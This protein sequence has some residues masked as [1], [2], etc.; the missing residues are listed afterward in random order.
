MIKN[1]V[2][3]FLGTL[4]FSILFNVPKKYY[5]YCGLTGMAGWLVYCAAEPFASATVAA[6]F[7]TLVVVLLSRIFAV[8]RKC[9]ITVFLISGI[10]PLVPGASVYYTAYY[11]VTGELRMAAIKGLDSVKIAFAIV[12]GI[13]CVFSIPKQWFQ[14]SHW[15]GRK[16][17]RKPENITKIRNI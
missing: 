5:M 3:S 4:A 11:L 17:E 6:F 14:V 1:I 7:G 13:A 15:K 16:K 2:C 9:P 12:F 8:W 10:F